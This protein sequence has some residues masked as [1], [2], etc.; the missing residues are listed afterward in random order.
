MMKLE[1]CMMDEGEKRNGG[2]LWICIGLQEKGI[3][4]P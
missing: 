1:R 3:W 2:D 4:G